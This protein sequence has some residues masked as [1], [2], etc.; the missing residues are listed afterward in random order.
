MVKHKNYLKL[1]LNI[2]NQPYNPEDYIK[3]LEDWISD[4]LSF[5]DDHFK[6]YFT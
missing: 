2:W 3:Q 6:N 5:C 4:R 1:D